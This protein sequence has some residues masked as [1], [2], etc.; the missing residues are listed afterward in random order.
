VGSNVSCE[1][2]TAYNKTDLNKILYSSNA[3]LRLTLDY[4]LIIICDFWG[5]S[6][7]FLQFRSI[8]IENYYYSNANLSGV[9]IVYEGAA[10]NVRKPVYSVQELDKK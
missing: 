2:G 3:T 8:C 5:L 6:V 9:C 4:K 10:E 1:T 7:D